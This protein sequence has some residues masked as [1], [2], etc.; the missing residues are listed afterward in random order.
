MS[1]SDKEAF[2]PGSVTPYTEEEDAKYSLWTKICVVKAACIKGMILNERGATLEADVAFDRVIPLLHMNGQA[3]AATPQLKYWSEQVL[4]EIAIIRSSQDHSDGGDTAIPA[5]RQ[6]AQLATKGTQP[7]GSAYGHA[8]QPRS[9]LS[10]WQAYYLR[11]SDILRKSQP[12]SLSHQRSDLVPELRRVETAY[13]N[14][15]LRNMQ[16]PKASQSNQIVE[17]WVEASHSK[18]GDSLWFPMARLGS[19]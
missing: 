4:A 1:G 16:F 19:R 15:L 7:Y 12:N 3:I 14:E 11:L 8:L 2:T 18:L 17:E 10:V 6:W 13:E 9:R 5:F